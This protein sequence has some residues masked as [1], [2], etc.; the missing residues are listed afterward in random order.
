MQQTPA[1]GLLRSHAGFDVDATQAATCLKRFQEQ[2]AGADVVR[3]NPRD[4]AVERLRP[5]LLNLAIGES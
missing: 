3:I 1:H 4:R 5:V 2:Q